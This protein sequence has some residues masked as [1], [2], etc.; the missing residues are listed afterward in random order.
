MEPEA[1]EQR[2]KINSGM[3]NRIIEECIIWLSPI[4]GSIVFFLIQKTGIRQLFVQMV[5]SIFGA[6][7]FSMLLRMNQR[8]YRHRIRHPAYFYGC[9]VL[10][11]L[12]LGLSGSSGSGCLWLLAV[13]FAALDAGVELAA[14]VNTSV[15]L[16]YAVMALGKEMNYRFLITYF[17]L[18]I[19]MSVLFSMLRRWWEAGY[20]FLVLVLFDAVC[21]IF[22]CDFS[23]SAF[24]ADGQALLEEFI[25]IL[26]LALVG[27]FY[28]TVLSPGLRLER[29]VVR[30]VITEK[31]VAFAEKTE[32]VQGTG[33]SEMEIKEDTGKEEIGKEKKIGKRHVDERHAEE[34]AVEE[35][36]VK[37]KP[38]REKRIKEK[39]SVREKKREAKNAGILQR[40]IQP[41]FPLLKK[42]R[43][44]SSTLYEHSRKI[45][46]LSGGA[47][48][49]IG[50]NEPLA[51]AGGMYHEIGRI[52]PS[53][54]YIV[55][56]E[57]IARDS[58]FPSE[59]LPVIR[60]HSPMYELPKSL[61]AAVVMLSDSIVSTEEYLMKNGQREQIS[62]EH[63]IENIFQKRI[64]KG[65]LSE[66]DLSDEEI[67]K[68]KEY[69]IQ[70]LGSL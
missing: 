30:S 41:D 44:Y 55:A 13:V 6:C 37:E 10:S 31:G 51:R 54:N 60:Q 46:E 45:S 24:L 67:K 47:A 4:L 64:S 23:I 1:K 25:S 12:W 70:N 63:L 48:R 59:L 56:G 50:G 22:A 53:G 65:N 16:I 19:M 36:A 18:G 7:A 40:I 58:V 57:K 11:F 69:F 27:V 61:E 28:I 2:K 14:F 62:D 52:T 43:F 42:L 68:L 21:R 20:L 29:V 33:V 3:K 66:V 32:P 38:V 26:A 35:K 5:L 8:F 49:L 15:M 17:I 34:K 9:Y 39:P